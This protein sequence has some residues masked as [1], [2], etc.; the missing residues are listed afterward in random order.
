MRSSMVAQS[1]NV[2]KLTSSGTGTATNGVGSSVMGGSG[3]GVAESAA[4]SLNLTRCRDAEIRRGAV[5]VLGGVE[6]RVAVGWVS[7]G[8]AL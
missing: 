6:A 2:L 7:S 3:S 8:G 1:A 4:A 5:P